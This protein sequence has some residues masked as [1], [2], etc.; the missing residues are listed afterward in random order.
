MKANGGRYTARMPRTRGLAIL[1]VFISS[2]ATA[3]GGDP[4]DREIQQAQTAIDAARSAGANDYAHDE[5]TA[6][7][8]ALTT[9][10]EA[11]NQRDYRLALTNAID[12]RERAQTAA[13]EAADQKTVVRRDIE[14]TL[15]ETTASLAQAKARLKAAEAGRAGRHALVASRR[16]IDDADRSVQ[17]ARAA[18]DAGDYV[19][20]KRTLDGVNARLAAAS[21]DLETIGNAP[22]RRRR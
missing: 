14:R 10:R 20:V 11:V 6:A 9:A 22:Q 2:L 7:E 13:K 19:A 21:R 8:K 15:R 12:S 16:A 17:E 1:W 4:P 5:F 18:F 3:C